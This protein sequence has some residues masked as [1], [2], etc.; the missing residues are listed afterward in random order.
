MS[1]FVE[2]IVTIEEQVV[3]IQSK[4]TP[5]TLKV[6]TLNRKIDGF[7]G[8]LTEI[9]GETNAIQQEINSTQQSLELIQTLLAETKTE[10]E[11]ISADQDENKH[12]YESMTEMFGEAFQVVSRFFETAQKIGIVDKEKTTNFL[13]LQQQMI[14]TEPV[15]AVS[16]PISEPMILPVTEESVIEKTSEP[17]AEIQKLQESVIVEEP[18]NLFDEIKELSDKNNIETNF[19]EPDTNSVSKIPDLTTPDLPD[20]PEFPESLPSVSDTETETIEIPVEVETLNLPPLQ[21]NT[22]NDLEDSKQTELSEEEE[23]KLEDLLADLS[24]PIST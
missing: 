9:V 19:D 10:G 21:L 17:V 16:E 14:K 8:L 7:S 4:I 5:L 24:T 18:F 20:V 1:P 2:K 12:L 6:E 23:K 11:Q 13:A 3:F 15:A 22:P